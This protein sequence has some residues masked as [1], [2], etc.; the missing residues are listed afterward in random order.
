MQAIYKCRMCEK[1]FSDTLLPD[2]EVDKCI[3]T[4]MVKKDWHKSYSGRTDVYK[5]IRHSH[6]DGSIGFADFIGFREEE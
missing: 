3:W 5:H 6:P 4:L 2:K 1:Q